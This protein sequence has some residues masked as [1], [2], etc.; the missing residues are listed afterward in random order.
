MRI[1]IR[2]AM[3]DMFNMKLI[4]ELEA[5]VAALENLMQQFQK[6]VKLERKKK[7]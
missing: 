1:F 5:R 3:V 2:A 6:L 7:K 4:K